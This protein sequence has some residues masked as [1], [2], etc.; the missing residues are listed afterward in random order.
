MLQVYNYVRNSQNVVYHPRKP[1]SPMKKKI[2]TEI[3]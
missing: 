2:F 1:N 3:N